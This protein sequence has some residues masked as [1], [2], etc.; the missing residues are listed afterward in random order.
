MF[1]PA[2]S[3]NLASDVLQTH[4]DYNLFYVAYPHFSFLSII[5]K[6]NNYLL[7]PVS[8]AVFAAEKKSK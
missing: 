6:V 5:I 3:D 1:S 2:N 7:L 4:I 8:T